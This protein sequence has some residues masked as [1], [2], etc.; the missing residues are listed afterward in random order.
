MATFYT[1]KQ[2]SLILG[3]STNSIYKFLESGRLKSSRG[4]SDSGRY[5][6]PHS[7]LEKFVGGPLP[8]AAV[9]EALRR[10]PAQNLPIKKEFDLPAEAAPNLPPAPPT[11]AFPVT[12]TRALIIVGLL[13]LLLDLVLSPNF[14]LFNQLLRLLV[15]GILI[16][17][18]Y[19]YGGLGSNSYGSK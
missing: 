7:S 12:L 6:I 5:K 2:V 18:T 16:L 8:E 4:N 19:Q 15:M 14:S 1:V 13:L 11:T 17:L 9:I 3:F 10:Y